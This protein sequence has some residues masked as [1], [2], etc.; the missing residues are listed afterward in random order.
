MIAVPGRLTLLMGPPFFDVSER[1]LNVAL[2]L[3]PSV[4]KHR[5]IYDPTSAVRYV[6]NDSGKIA[7]RVFAVLGMKK[8]DLAKLEEKVAASAV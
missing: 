1:L 3:W 5:Q 7:G 8:H 4:K 6:V 2:H